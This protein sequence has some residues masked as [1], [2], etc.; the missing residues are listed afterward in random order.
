MPVRSASKLAA[1]PVTRTFRP[2]ELKKK[3]PVKSSFRPIHNPTNGKKPIRKKKTCRGRIR[4]RSA[5]TNATN[6]NHIATAR[7][8]V[9][10]PHRRPQ[11]PQA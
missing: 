11:R 6:G 2:D 7:H 4:H 3:W 1:Q 8:N 9:A 5:A 10:N